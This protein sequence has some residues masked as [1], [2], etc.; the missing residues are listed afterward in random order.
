M[1]SHLDMF[2]EFFKIKLLYTSYLIFYMNNCLDIHE[3]FIDNTYT[4]YL[5]IRIIIRMGLHYKSRP[6]PLKCQDLHCT[7]LIS[8]CSAPSGSFGSGSMSCLR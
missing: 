3:V 1:N 2:E 8:I 6:G 4:I 5:Y 7:C